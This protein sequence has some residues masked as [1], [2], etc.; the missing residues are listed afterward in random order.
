[1]DTFVLGTYNIFNF[2]HKGGTMYQ[3][4]LARNKFSKEVIQRIFFPTVVICTLI[5]K[6]NL[7]VSASKTLIIQQ[8]FFVAQHNSGLSGTQGKENPEGN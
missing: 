5:S 4:L 3:K 8:Q 7:E 2:L 1:M 6:A